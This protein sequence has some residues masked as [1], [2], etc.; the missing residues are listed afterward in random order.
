MQTSEGKA[1]KDFK[2]IRTREDVLAALRTYMSG[3]PGL[4]VGMLAHCRGNGIVGTT[5]E[6]DAARD[7]HT[8]VVLPIVPTG[9]FP[10]EG[11]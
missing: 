11:T 1:L 9:A 2:T 3:A 7:V 6:S 4:K 10:K 8:R 5:V